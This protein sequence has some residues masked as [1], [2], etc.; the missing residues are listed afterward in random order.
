MRAA[1]AAVEGLELLRLCNLRREER[2]DPPLHVR[3]G[4]AMGRFLYGVFGK[5]RRRD[6]TAIGHTV[7]LAARVQ[8]IEP[9]QAGC[10]KRGGEDGQGTILVGGE[11]GA[12]LERSGRFLLRKLEDA[13]LRNVAHPIPIWQLLG[14]STE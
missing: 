5:S 6:L 11:M 12:E 14:R 3:V 10:A 1:Q 2:G 13:R 4:L 8:G 9:E 7:N